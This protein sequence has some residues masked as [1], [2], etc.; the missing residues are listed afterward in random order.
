MVFYH[1]YPSVLRGGFVGVDVFFVISG[2]LITGHMVREVEARGRIDLIGFYARRARRLMP[3]ATVVLVV[4]WLA[5]LVV[6]PGSRL[7]NTARQVAASALYGQNWLLAHDSVDY[8][9]AEDAASPVQHYWSLSVEEQFYLGW[10]VLLIG[11]VMLARRLH[12]NW[13]TTVMVLGGSLVVVSLVLSVRLTASNGGAAYF[14]T[15]T[16]VWE[17]GLGAL[18]AVWGG[19]DR[20]SARWA[21]LLRC[22]GLV[23]IG[24]SACLF[25]SSTAFPGS[26]ALLPVIGSLLVLAAGATADSRVLGARPMTLLGDLSYSLYLVHWPL[27]VL[28][29]SWSHGDVGYLD[30]PVLVL[31]ALALAWC[32]KRLVEDPVRLSRAFASR[33][34]GLALTLCAV[35]PVALVYTHLHAPSM[36]N[37]SAAISAA[38]PGAAVLAG[39][40]RA[41]DS[42]ETALPRPEDAPLDRPDYYAQGCEVAIATAGVKKCEFGETDRAVATI[43]LVGDSKVGQL[44]PAFQALART[45]HWHIVTYLRSRCPWSS[46]L[47]TVGDGNESPY[48]YCQDWGR[49]VLAALSSGPAPDV[50]VTADRPVVGVPEHPEPDEVSYGAIARGMT[51]YWEAS[52]ARGTEV[53]AVKET[54]EMGQDVPDCLSAPNASIAS[55]SRSVAEA[56]TPDPPT[57]QATRAMQGRVPL[58]DLTDEICGGGVCSPIVGDVV[59]YR[60][61]HHLTRTFT[62]SLAPYLG[63]A[64]VDAGAIDALD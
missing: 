56:L 51:T 33:G 55:C 44:L 28:W 14:I 25:S 17:L 57:L 49:D 4:T 1:L 48:T 64:L 53:V 23:A 38:H 18:L 39:D 59:V 46:T 52:L 37:A 36:P 41:V 60:D 11:A 13:R 30:G 27:I 61:A 42:L 45:N 22:G 6:L 7:L 43:A 8:L 26:A 58:V 63:R 3:A 15:P 24:L 12:R 47:T 40:A 34:R 20:M 10:P 2:Y 32:L 29:A 5:A 31:T 62:E 35:L 21:V 16:R 19:A 50:L 54:P 9:T